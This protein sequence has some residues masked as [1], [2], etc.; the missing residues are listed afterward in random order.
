LTV[1]LAFGST[2]TFFEESCP[3]AT[4]G[5]VFLVG[6]GELTMNS[7]P[8]MQ[9]SDMAAPPRDTVDAVVTCHGPMVFRV[10]LRVLHDR[11]EA[12]DVVQLA[13]IEFA[14]H[15]DV[16]G[17]HVAAWLHRTATNAARDLLRSRARR[18]RRERAAGRPA[19]VG[20]GDDPDELREELDAALDRLPVEMREA[21][22]LHHLEGRDYSESARLVG[23]SEEALRKRTQ[24]GLRQLR[25][26]LMSRGVVCSLGGLA[27]FLGA[28]SAANA[29]LPA[30]L[31][32]GLLRLSDAQSPALPTATVSRSALRVALEAKI[33]WLAAVVVLGS[34]AVAYL[35]AHALALRGVAPAFAEPV[36]GW[37]AG[38]RAR[39]R[40][41][42]LEGAATVSSSRPIFSSRNGGRDVFVLPRWGEFTVQGIPFQV[43]DPQNG[44][45]PNVIA[46]RSPL[47]DYSRALPESAALRC[48]T[49]ARV[50][51]LL[52]GV[53]GW[54]YPT[55]RGHSLSMVVQISYAGGSKEAHYLLNGAHFASFAGT[56]SV[57]GSGPALRLRFGN[58]V[59]YLAITPSRSEPID[60]IDFLKGDDVTAPVVMAV[61]VELEGGRRTVR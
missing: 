18:A 29:A 23:C 19:V 20:S 28:E 34:G 26:R 32:E 49:P 17:H 21:V 1:D 5:V 33:A 36:S 39:Y 9:I 52:S 27:L 57:P 42:S 59:R 47:G 3:A 54:G 61:T 35:G 60:R 15:R 45:V 16:A 25:D 7:D 38:A 43:L 58:Q 13:F 6:G 53:S 30:N 11:H 41:L 24:R 48:G 2:R 14:K 10:A 31:A 22:V 40:P 37:P 50:I 4:L 56:A 55:D 46:L 44:S 51:H 12:E 8:E